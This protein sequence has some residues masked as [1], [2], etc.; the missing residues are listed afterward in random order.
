[1]SVVE[2]VVVIDGLVGGQTANR[3]DGNYAALDFCGI[4]RLAAGWQC[5][6]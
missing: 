2:V 1:M 5:R 6:G 4:G 3:H